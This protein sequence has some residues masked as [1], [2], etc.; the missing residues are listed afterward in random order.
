MIQA[1]TLYTPPCRCLFSLFSLVYAAFVSRFH[2]NRC[3]ILVGSGE[4]DIKCS[5]GAKY[6]CLIINLMYIAESG[7]IK[8]N[9][10]I[11]YYCWVNALL[12]EICHIMGRKEFTLLFSL[13]M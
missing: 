5:C 11:N 12:K 13:M 6:C 10:F 1:N 2:V 9:A 3:F 8:K 7:N 4:E